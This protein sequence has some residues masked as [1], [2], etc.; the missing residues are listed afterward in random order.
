MLETKTKVKFFGFPTSF[1]C[2]ISI[3]TYET[4][5]KFPIKMVLFGIF[6]DILAA[7]ALDILSYESL[8]GY[9]YIYL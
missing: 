6:E 7:A 5:I 8:S 9:S 2:N 1:V 4:Y 3:L